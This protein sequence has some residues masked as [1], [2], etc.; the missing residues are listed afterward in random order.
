[1]NDDDAKG[2]K[3]VKLPTFNG[4]AKEAQIWLMRFRAY[5]DVYGFS[6]SIMKIADPD[7]PAKESSAIDETTDA[8]KKEAKAKRVRPI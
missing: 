4:E 1:M 3:T 2:N 6:Q 7:L 5:A 8:G